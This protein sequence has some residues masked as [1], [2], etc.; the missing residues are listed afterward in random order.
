MKRTFEMKFKMYCWHI[1]R[2]ICN[3]GIATKQKVDSEVCS[4][5]C[6]FKVLKFIG[7][8]WWCGAQYNVYAIQQWKREDLK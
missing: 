7:S 1:N 3:I 8:V 4:V 2:L 5:I 6:K